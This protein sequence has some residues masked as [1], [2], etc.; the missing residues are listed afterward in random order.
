MADSLALLTNKA[1]LAI[2]QDPLG[3][4]PFRYY[5]NATDGVDI[6]RKDL[7]GGDV[8]LAIVNMGTAEP[9]PPPSEWRTNAPGIVFTD[10]VCTNMGRTKDCS[11]ATD[12]VACCRT[13]C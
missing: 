12:T 6:W 8:A 5:S 11:Q 9:Q 4:M 3:R 7:V 2:N 1:V 10:D 13:T